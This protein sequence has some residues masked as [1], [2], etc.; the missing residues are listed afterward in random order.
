MCC[1]DL[2]IRGACCCC[3]AFCNDSCRYLKRFF[4]LSIR[5]QM[6]LAYLS[7]FGFFVAFVLSIMKFSPSWLGLWSRF[8]H[9]P[10]ISLTKDDSLA[11]IGVSALYRMGASLVVLFGI[12]L[13]LCLLHN[14]TSKFFNENF[15]FHK[16][17]GLLAL[18]FAQMWISNDTY[19]LYSYLGQIGGVIFAI[20]EIVMVIDL[21]YSWSEAWVSGYE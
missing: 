7:L 4:T 3:Q 1:F 17:L 2:C 16:T 21:A 18:F 9:C 19:Q 12:L 20:F 5:Q 8:L 13:L 15:W 10:E 6:R 11:C 14:E